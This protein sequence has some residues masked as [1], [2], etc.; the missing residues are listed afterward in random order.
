MLV[1]H[2]LWGIL[3]NKEFQEERLF[4]FVLYTIRLTIVVLFNESYNLIVIYSLIVG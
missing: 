1:Q 4:L 3:Q 2:L